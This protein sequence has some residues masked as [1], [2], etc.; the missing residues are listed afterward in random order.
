MEKYLRR[1]EEYLNNL[2]I[3]F[4][5][6][7]VYEPKFGGFQTNY[8][9]NGRRTKV[10]EK[11]LLSQGRVIFAQSFVLRNGFQYPGLQE[12]IGKGKDFLLKYFKD[13]EYGGYYWITTE[14]GRPIDDSKV[15][16]GHAFLIYG[17]SEYAMLSG[18]KTCRDEAINIFN[19]LQE[20]IKDT[21]NGGYNE[22]FDRKFNPLIT[23]TDE[24]YHKSLDVH[25]HLMEA[26]TSLYEMTGENEHR[27]ALEEVCELIF[28]KMVD[29]KTGTGIS[30][31]TTDWQAIPNV[32][33]KTVWGKDRFP[34]NGKPID[35]TSYGHN[36]EMG[37]LYHHTLKI[38]G[39]TDKKYYDR[40]LPLYEHTYNH[41]VDWEYGGI[42]VEGHREGSVTEMNKEF[43]QQGEAMIGFLDAY[44]LTN[45]EKYLDAFRK[46]HDFV[47]SSMINWSLGEWFP[48]LNHS[49]NIISASMGYNWKSGYHTLRATVLVIKKLREI[50]KIDN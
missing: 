3:P 43:W 18:D 28:D 30:M 29:P 46:V 40:I 38:L 21:A 50:L 41:G 24:I 36:I 45:D 9:R 34:R 26:F 25:M 17:L 22:H 27:K 1:T 6:K 5:A 49:G 15:I 8:S 35:I 44:Q 48:L 42:F 13:P 31:F 33:L 7:R 10:T 14:D 12:I 11:A 39:L 47:F 23:R 19:F 32:E 2:L 37:W 4:W 20:K 16:Y